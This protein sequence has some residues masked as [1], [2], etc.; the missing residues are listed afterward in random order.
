MKICSKFFICSGFLP[1]YM[2]FK[3]FSHSVVFFHV[4]LPTEVI[5][6]ISEQNNDYSENFDFRRKRMKEVGWACFLFRRSLITNPRV[7]IDSLIVIYV[8]IRTHDTGRSF[9]P[10]FMK[11]ALFVRFQQ[12]MSPI[13][14]ETIGPVDPQR[15]GGNGAP[16]TSF[17]SFSQTVWFFLFFFRKKLKTVFDTR[18]SHRKGYIHFCC[19][20]SRSRKN[21]RG[22][23]KY[24]SRV[25]FL[26]NIGF[27]F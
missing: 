19:P 1:P 3:M 21:S 18:I 9:K 11:F 26:E 20:T 25:F 6:N 17:F 10:I 8:H 24:F 12:W 5:S 13:V 27:F 16:K 4:S 2:V 7:N 14:F 23:Q 15:C 22:S